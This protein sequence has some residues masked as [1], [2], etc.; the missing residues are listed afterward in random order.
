MQISEAELNKL[1]RALESK[2]NQISRLRAASSSGLNTLMVVGEAAFGAVAMGY[3]IGML[4][5]GGHDGMIAGFPIELGTGVAVAAISV[6]LASRSNTA[7]YASHVGNVASGI[8]AHYLGKVAE[9]F[10]NTGK[11]ALV[12]GGGSDFSGLYSRQLLAGNRVGVGSLDE[13]L[14]G[15]AA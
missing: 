2:D 11:L 9:G 5:K 15:V 13:V 1:G 4:K 3:T 7:K 6:F 12:A 10:G 14:A 8:L